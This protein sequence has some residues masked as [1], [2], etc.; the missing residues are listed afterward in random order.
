M[1]LARRILHSGRPVKVQESDCKQNSPSAF[2]GW[3]FSFLIKMKRTEQ[4]VLSSLFR[5]Q[6]LASS[7]T[8]VAVENDDDDGL[9]FPC[10]PLH[11]NQLYFRLP[12]FVN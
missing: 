6:V 2:S 3:T 1:F 10:S 8:V 11:P 4:M 9:A 5:R 12:L 7:Y